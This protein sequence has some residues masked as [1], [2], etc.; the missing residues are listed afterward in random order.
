MGK[1][2]LDAASGGALVNK[3]LVVAKTLIENM[4]LNSQQFTT[5]N[6]YVVLTKRVHEIQDSSSNKVLETIIDELTSLVRQLT[7]GKTQT[8]RLCGICISP[9]H[10]T[11][12]CPTLQKGVKL[13]LP[14]VYAANIYNPQSNNQYRYNTF[15]LSTN[16]YYS[17]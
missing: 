11:N 3:T 10:P 12:T 6:N 15:D 8:E 4:P 7:V 5:R 17:N 2:T 16:K 1:N 14:H 13:Y 9:E